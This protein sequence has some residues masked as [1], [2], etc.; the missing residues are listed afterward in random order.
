MVK[1]ETMQQ[2]LI[3]SMNWGP[4]TRTQDTLASIRASSCYIKIRRISYNK[5]EYLAQELEPL[6]KINT[7]L[8]L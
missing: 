8:A 1:V 7:T 2:L 5:I 3:T 4:I 6:L